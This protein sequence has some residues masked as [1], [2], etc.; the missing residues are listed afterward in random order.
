MKDRLTDK[1]VKKL[2]ALRQEK[3]N[4]KEIVYKDGHSENKGYTRK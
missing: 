4:A 3:I 1:E 2:K